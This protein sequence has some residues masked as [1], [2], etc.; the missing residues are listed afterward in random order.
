MVGSTGVVV[1]VVVGI[2]IGLAA[3]GGGFVVIAS[4]RGSAKHDDHDQHDQ[5]DDQ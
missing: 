4:R 2:L 3:G 1:G 5:H